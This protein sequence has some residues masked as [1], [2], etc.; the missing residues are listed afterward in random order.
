MSVRGEVVHE[1]R[2]C[3]CKHSD[4]FV[5]GQHGACEIWIVSAVGMAPVRIPEI[6]VVCV[7]ECLQT[8][9]VVVLH[10]R[11]CLELPCQV[12][13]ENF[14]VVVGVRVVFHNSRWLKGKCK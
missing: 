4:G 2:T 13:L 7:V 5:S 8:S 6:V 9:V 12:H 11:H 14:R 1:S 3:P 10:Q